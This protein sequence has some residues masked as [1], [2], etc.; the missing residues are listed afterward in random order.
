MLNGQIQ[1]KGVRRENAAEEE[2][3]FFFE[4]KG[5]HLGLGGGGV[6]FPRKIPGK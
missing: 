6:T 5:V 4:S 3:A 2:N 1:R